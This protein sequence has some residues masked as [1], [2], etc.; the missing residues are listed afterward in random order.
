MRGPLHAVAQNVSCPLSLNKSLTSWTHFFYFDIV[1]CTHGVC[2]GHRYGAWCLGTIYS[3]EISGVTLRKC[4]LTIMSYYLSSCFS[5]KLDPRRAPHILHW[6]IRVMRIITDP[7]TDSV[8]YILN[9]LFV[10]LILRLAR[11]ALILIIWSIMVLVRL[12]A[13]PEPV[14]KFLQ[15]F[16]SV[17]RLLPHLYHLPTS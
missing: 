12:I 2:V 6:P 7:I 9:K 14:E 1:G 4:T 15:H 17:V 13:G 8:I 3:W 10:P 5:S 16:A 11:S